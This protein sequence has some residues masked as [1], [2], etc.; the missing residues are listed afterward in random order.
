MLFNQIPMHGLLWDYLHQNFNVAFKTEEFAFCVRKGRQVVPF[1]LAAITHLASPNPQAPS[2]DTQLEFCIVQ[3]GS[4]IAAM[5]INA[6]TFHPGNSQILDATNSVIASGPITR[7]GQMYAPSATTSWPLT[8]KG[9]VHVLVRFNAGGIT[10]QPST[11]ILHLKGTKGE[12]LGE[13]R[14]AE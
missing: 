6:G 7:A 13:M 11:T 1:N 4:P 10:L 2:Y 9:P 3:D 5:A 12:A 14:I 8:G